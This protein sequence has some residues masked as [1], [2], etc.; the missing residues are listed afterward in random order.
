[1]YIERGERARRGIYLSSPVLERHRQVDFY[2]FQA[3]LLY[4]DF[5]VTMFF[6]SGSKL[7]KDTK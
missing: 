5:Q 2:E 4:F 1:M 3:S 6:I 7:A